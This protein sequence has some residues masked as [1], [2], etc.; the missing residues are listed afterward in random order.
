MYQYTGRMGRSLRKAFS[1]GQQGVAFG[2]SP[3]WHVLKLCVMPAGI[4]FRHLSSTCRGRSEGPCSRYPT[5]G[6]KIVI[7]LKHRSDVGGPP[8]A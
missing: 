4:C 1:L 3:V 2:W 8:F 6:G 5:P 7:L